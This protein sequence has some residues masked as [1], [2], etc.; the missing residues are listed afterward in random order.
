MTQIE[1]CYTNKI[2]IT[3][4]VEITLEQPEVTLTKNG[5]LTKI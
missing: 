2:Y 5:N 4:P 3:N 1:G